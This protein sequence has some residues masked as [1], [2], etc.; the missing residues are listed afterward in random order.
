MKSSRP[1]GRSTRRSSRSAR[2]WSSTRAEH[3]RR[4]DRVEAV[5]LERQVL[6]RR[7]QDAS[8]ASAA[9]E[10]PLQPLHHRRLRLG[11]RQRLVRRRR[12]SRGSRR[13]RRRSRAR[14][15]SR[16]RA[17]PRGAPR[18]RPSRSRPSCGRTAMRR[19]VPRC[20][21]VNRTPSRVGGRGAF[22]PSSGRYARARHVARRDLP[23]PDPAPR[24]PAGR[25]RDR[26]RRAPGA[27]RRRR[28][29][30]PRSR[31]QSIRE[32]T[33]EVRDTEPRRR[34]SRPALD[35]AARRARAV[36]PRPRVHAPR[37]RQAARSAARTRSRPSRTMRDIYTPGVARVC[38]AIAE[39]PEL[40]G[41]LHDDRAQRRDLH[42]RDARA[43]AGRHRP[44]RR[45]AGDGGQGHLL[46]PVRR[47]RARCRS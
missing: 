33:V 2:G 40:A 29:G 7:A 31:T 14:R 32:I 10:L 46:R 17:A 9:R 34:D 41:A 6:G 45:D 24:R 25:G 26:D 15:R 35:D 12:S 1:P 5:V 36:A 20:S 27:D 42:Q 23:R 22:A 47:P 18:A 21:W 19:R 13:C 38:P 4:D 8:P 11:D 16:R 39:N 28:D 37:R 30:Q 3:E 43:R 44:G